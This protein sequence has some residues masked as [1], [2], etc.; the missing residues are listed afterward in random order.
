MDMYYWLKKY[1]H[2]KNLAKKM[3]LMINMVLH[4]K[5]IQM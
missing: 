1:Q 5:V 3:G 4:H 2:F